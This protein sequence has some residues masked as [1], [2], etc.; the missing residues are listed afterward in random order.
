M[1]AVVVIGHNVYRFLPN[2]VPILVLILWISLLIRRKPWKSIGLS[3]PGSWGVSLA[4][5]IAA[6]ALLQLKDFVTEPFAHWIWPQPEKSSS[7]LADLHQHSISHAALSLA[8]VWSFAAFGE[9]FAYRAL[10]LRRAADALNG[11]RVGYA[12][13]ILFSSLLFGFG[14]FYKGP[15]GVFD[16]T[17]SGLI[18]AAAYLL[19][20]RNLWAPIFAHG[21]SDT[22]A[23]AA[24]YFA[25]F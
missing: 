7:I 22:F 23:V 6:G 8:I 4:V 11:S 25:L 17:I 13:A 15:T 5:A 1:G 18:L 20:R 21:L 16:S 2:E 14:H 10:L 12:I 9:E 19:T 24:S 3:K